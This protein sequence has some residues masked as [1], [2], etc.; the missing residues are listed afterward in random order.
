M[1]SLNIFTLHLLQN[2]HSAD[3]PARDA[4]KLLIQMLDFPE[5]KDELFECRE[6]AYAGL[7]R[8]IGDYVKAVQIIVLVKEAAELKKATDKQLLEL[9]VEIDR[10][11]N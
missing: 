6:Q 10:L 3:I 11:S 8:D 1:K 5:L 7:N 4:A 9:Q 2:C